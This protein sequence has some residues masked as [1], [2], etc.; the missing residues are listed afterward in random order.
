MQ[1]AMH[2]GISKILIVVLLV[3]GWLGGSIPPEKI[4]ASGAVQPEG[5][6]AAVQVFGED[7]ES[8]AAGAVPA[9][10]V[11]PAAAN[12]YAQVVDKTGFSGE[13]ALKLVKHEDSSAFTE[14]MRVF[15]AQTQVFTVEYEFRLDTSTQKDLW[16]D[17]D[18]TQPFP[19]GLGLIAYKTASSNMKSF[20]GGTLTEL[21]D[22]KLVAGAWYSV[23]LEIDPAARSYDLYLDGR[24]LADSFTFRNETKSMLDRITFWFDAAAASGI[25]YIDDLRVYAGQLPQPE[26]LTVYEATYEWP[27]GGIYITSPSDPASFTLMGDHMEMGQISVVP[28]VYGLPF[29]SMLRAETVEYPPTTYDTQVVLPSLTRIEQGDTLVVRFYVR[30]EGGSGRTQALIEK[31]GNPYTKSLMQ[32]VRVKEEW[33]LIQF[34]ARSLESYEPGEAKFIFRLGYQPQILYFGGVEVRNYGQA[35]KPEQFANYG[36][37][38]DKSIPAYEG[39]EADAA[40]RADAADRIEQYRKGALQVA[41]TDGDGAPLAQAQVEVRM[42]KHAFSFGTS[43]NDDFLNGMAKDTAD[44][45]RYRQEVERLFNTAVIEN[46]MKG[47]RYGLAGKAEQVAKELDWLDDIGIKVR[48]HNLIWQEWKWSPPSFEAA[49]NNPALLRQTARD[50]VTDTATLFRGKVFEWDVINEPIDHHVMEDIVG[51]EEKYEWIRLARE[52]DPDALV[53]INEFD[54]LEEPINIHNWEEKQDKMAAIL[55]EASQRGTPVDGLGLQNHFRENLT[56]PAQVYEIVDRYAQLVPFIKSTELDINIQDEEVQG[57]YMRDFMTVMFSH[58]QVDGILVWGFWD[59]MHYAS[60]A[61][62]FRKDWSLKPSGQAYM[63]LVFD[64][65]WSDADGWT[66]ASGAYETRGFLGEYEITVTVGNETRTVNVSLPA[67]GAAVAIQL[68]ATPAP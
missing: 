37:Y 43:I 60:N 41:V 16:A 24:K 62:I 26:P 2:I 5:R 18:N 30:S 66:D 57:R 3:V 33:Q 11:L 51:A 8:Y 63:D 65:W 67:E 28:A 1:R 46:N 35:L 49:K 13:K 21:P 15:P 61:P 32:Q 34:S 10:W 42:T 56:P 6:T 55:E 40:W 39:A 17:V 48:G 38:Q 68:N 50:Y 20:Q 4:L 45:A 47:H 44:A 12:G 31:N 59:G 58:P 27:A 53:Y 19:Y 7:F 52:A 9:N 54:I 36:I 64:Q 23:R 14:F 29:S 22:S 25:A